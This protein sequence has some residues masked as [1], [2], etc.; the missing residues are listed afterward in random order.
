MV[1]LDFDQFVSV[2]TTVVV[3][4]G[5]FSWWCGDGKGGCLKH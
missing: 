1:K 4:W 5:C 2:F 3:I